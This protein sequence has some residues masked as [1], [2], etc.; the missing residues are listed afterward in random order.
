MAE[1][2]G[3]MSIYDA[4]GQELDSPQAARA[5]RYLQGAIDNGW[6]PVVSLTMR[7]T[8]PD[9]TPTKAGEMPAKPFFVTWQLNGF[10]EKTGKL[11]WRFHSARAANG[12]AL[13]ESDIPVVLENPEVV[14]PEPPDELCEAAQYDDPDQ[15]I[16]GALG[17]VAPISK[18]DPAYI[19][20]PPAK[21]AHPDPTFDGWA[22]LR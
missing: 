5:P 22:V 3:Q 6:V 4:L 12:Q 8:K 13:S 16:R 9:D 10:T 2:D 20:G 18:P 1:L 7:L 15:T 14:Y 21:P 17:A 19:N 11:S